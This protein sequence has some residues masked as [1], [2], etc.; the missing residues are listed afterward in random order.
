MI[1]SK[2]G[3]KNGLY[4]PN[5]RRSSF[6]PPAFCEYFTFYS[7]IRKDMHQK[8][9]LHIWQVTSG[10][11]INSTG[12]FKAHLVEWSVVLTFEIMWFGNYVILEPW[13]WGFNFLWCTF[14]LHQ[15]R[16]DSILSPN[17]M[18]FCRDQSAWTLHGP[19]QSGSSLYKIHVECTRTC[20]GV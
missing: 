2:N 5:Q 18:S 6:K 1:P 12:H 19:A 8:C 17:L 3:F 11:Y 13:V 10:H 20:E 16:S 7:L 4:C 15:F 9:P 14:F